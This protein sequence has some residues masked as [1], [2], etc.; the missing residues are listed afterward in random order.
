MAFPVG[1]AIGLGGSLVSGLFGGAQQSAQNR[2]AEKQAQLAHE[3]NLA[4]WKFNKISA[5]R[6]YTYDKQ[7]VQIQRRN[8][9]Q[10]LAYQEATADQSWR[11]QMQ[12]Q[13]FDY[14]NDLRAYNKSSKTAL[15]QI[16]YNNLAYDYALQDSA[17]WEL[18]QNIALD[19]ENKSTMMEY[20]Y[21]QRGQQL[22]LL[23]AGAEL[24]QITEV[25]ELQRQEA[26]L[27]NVINPLYAGEQETRQAEVAI[28]QLRGSGQLRQQ[29]EYIE[30]LKQ[31]GQA[32]ARGAT[33]VSA[34]KV[35]QA[36]IAE[37]GARTASIIQEVFNGEQNYALTSEAVDQNLKKGRRQYEMAT[38]MVAQDL[39]A[40]QRNF[41]IAN[42]GIAAKLEQLNDQFYL[43]KA[44]LAASRSSLAAQGKSTRY[45]AALGKYQA[46]MNAMANMML[47]PVIPPAI[48]KP[49][50]L[51]RPTL[52]DPMEFDK[53]MWA[54]I[55]PKKGA[56]GGMSP[57]AAGL[58]QFAS[59]AF[60]AAL[61]SWNPATKSFG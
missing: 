53:K 59:G 5:R 31:M 46:D 22:S 25:A 27:Q 50:A 21:A 12:I 37:T 36:A 4:N 54:G 57:V 1:L 42:M 6:Q 8:L 10:N 38:R 11:N 26:Y 20:H 51:P 17:R 35:A 24:Q 32:T 40:G 34:E 39:K 52:Q 7:S 14:A 41:A 3:A 9:E 28:Q 2:A 47:E 55:R 29:Q 15:E 58:G 45:E 13:A 43:D 19:F 49:M 48:P 16:G 18:E 44:Q 33:G 23:Q 30:G 60:N 56:V 61:S